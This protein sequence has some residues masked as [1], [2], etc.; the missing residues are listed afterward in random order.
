VAATSCPAAPAAAARQLYRAAGRE[1]PG[2]VLA[3]TDPAAFARLLQAA[4]RPPGPAT[5]LLLMAG[6]L[7]PGAL[8]ALGW[9]HGVTDPAFG[10]LLLVL[11]VLLLLAAF[12]PQ[13]GS[14]PTPDRV[15]AD[16]AAV[17]L[18]VAAAAA[19]TAVVAGSP[20]A[21]VAAFALSASLAGLLRAA[22]LANGGVPGRL[23]LAAATG[24]SLAALASE[25]INEGLARE[26]EDALAERRVGPILPAHPL[27]I[28]DRDG[29][30]HLEE[31]SRRRLGWARHEQAPILG[32]LV[33]AHRRHALLAA[34]GLADPPALLAAALRL[35]RRCEA[36][37][38]FEG[39]AVVL[40]RHDGEPARRAPPRW[41]RPAS[42]PY[43][44][45]LELLQASPV[46]HL[47]IALASSTGL[48]D[49][50]LARL[51]AGDPDPALRVD[52]IE[53]IGFERFFAALGASPVDRG[54]AGALF[55]AGQRPLGT[56]VVRVEDKARDAH[57]RPRVHWLPVPPH[58]AIAREAVARTFG[59]R[60]QDWDPLVET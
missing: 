38:L 50:L 6:S 56:A 52:A 23:G 27:S 33:P 11:G 17:L 31:V 42:P 59:K 58:V 22:A 60:E 3:A 25:P 1:P 54:A 35:D 57:G 36:V 14:E 9:A 20:A 34:E 39:A 19:L 55:V 37:S 12:G 18:L 5:P 8:A 28:A 15:R 48:A 10:G 49:R 40:L 26:L 44:P 4:G 13:A 43:A 41:W 7:V 16:T 47:A 2:L 45:I 30:R 32:R 24:T 51:V 29:W 21:G 46:W 53:R